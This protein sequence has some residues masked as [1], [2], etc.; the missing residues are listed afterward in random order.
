MIHCLFIVLILWGGPQQPPQLTITITHTKSQGGMVRVLIFQGA[1]GFP[2]QPEKAFKQIS[3]QMDEGKAVYN[4]E[5]LEEGTYAISAFLDHDRDG[6]MRIGTF[7]IPKDPYGFSNN[8]RG[9]FGPPD[10]KKAAFEVKEGNNEVYI[11]LN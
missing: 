4:L 5:H 10:Y 9:L 8:V 2:D 11:Q 3:V 6:K 7:G 1:E